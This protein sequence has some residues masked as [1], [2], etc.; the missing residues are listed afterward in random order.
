M[1]NVFVSSIYQ[2]AGKTTLSLG[3][4]K[5][6]VERGLAT[7]FMK[8]L[9]QQTVVVK[10]HNIDK[11]TY[12]I[13]EVYHCRRQYKEMSPVTIGPG[14]TEE[15]IFK[16]NNDVLRAKIEKSFKSLTRGKDAIIIEGTGHAGVGSVIDLSN[17][18]VAAMLGSKV[19]IVSEGGIGRSIDEIMLNK[20]LFDLKH[21]EVVGVVV[22]KVLPEKYDKVKKALAQGLKN[23]GIRLLGVLPLDLIL[24]APTIEHLMSRL[25]LKLLSGKSRLNS[26]VHAT[27]V[28]AMEPHNMVNYL[29]ANTLVLTSGDRVDNIMVAVTSHLI[30]PGKRGQISGIILTGGLMPNEKIMDLLKKSRIPVLITNDDTFTIA[31]KIENLICKIQKQDK[32]KIAEA[33]QL[34]KQHVDVDTILNAL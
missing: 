17:A 30:N 27:I 3:L 23:K 25:S 2:N 34:I 18:D 14:F 24:K 9:G 31:G 19:I 1:K 20:A 15:Y 21:V 22:N 12:L 28:A 33:C 16:P 32:D 10:E 11:D 29:K 4:Y 26:H 13:G 8:P 7:A 6:F 5:V